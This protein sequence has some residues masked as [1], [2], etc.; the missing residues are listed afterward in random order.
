MLMRGLITFCFACFYFFRDRDDAHMHI[1][2][3]SHKFLQLFNFEQQQANETRKKGINAYL[4][5]LGLFTAT[6]LMNIRIFMRVSVCVQKCVAI[7]LFSAKVW[8]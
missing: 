2:I 5:L 1:R 3:Y 8:H 4:L 6:S 7:Y